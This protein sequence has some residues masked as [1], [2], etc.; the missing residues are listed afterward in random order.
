MYMLRLILGAA[1]NPTVR[2]EILTALSRVPNSEAARCVVGGLIAANNDLITAV[3]LIE[4]MVTNE[5]G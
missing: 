1:K 2:N 5:S 4:A 3:Q